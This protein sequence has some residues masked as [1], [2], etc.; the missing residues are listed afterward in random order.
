RG[1]YLSW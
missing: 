1:L